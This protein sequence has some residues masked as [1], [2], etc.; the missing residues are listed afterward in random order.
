MR[1]V[2]YLSP[3]SI[4]KYYENT[5]EFYLQYLAENRPDRIPQTRPMSIGSA[6]D[7]YAKSYL[8]EKLFGKDNDVRFQFETIFEAQVEK[9]N[10]DWAKEAGKYAFDCYHQSGALSDLMIE[11]SSAI[12]TPRFE[13]E[14]RGVI[15]GVREGT[16]LDIGPMTLLGKPDCWFINKTGAHVILDWKVN[17]FCS[18]WGVSPMQGYVRLRAKKSGRW[19]NLGQH[20]GSMCMMH[21]GMMINMSAYLE[22]FDM[23]WARQLTIY[24]FLLGED[25]GGDFIVAVDQLA[26]K[27]NTEKFPDIRIAEHRLRIA[28]ETQWKIFADAQHVWEVC[29]SNHIFREMS[30]EESVARC[31]M[32]EHTATVLKGDGSTTDKWFNNS[33][34]G[35]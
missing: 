9:Q 15:N 6:F 35:N 4:S 7:A 11:L 8:H 22:N 1:N 30:Q 13:F 5:T 24:A 10:R 25:I 21:N 28:H 3:T 16:T 18:D 32:L 14:I 29:H 19:A 12:G 31:L 23:N 20:K 27:L 26:C 17:G 2:Q 33:C 34:R